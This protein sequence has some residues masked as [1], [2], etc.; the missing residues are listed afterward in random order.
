MA[1]QKSSQINGKEGK[2]EMVSLSRFFKIMDRMRRAWQNISPGPQLNKSQFVTLMTIQALGNVGES[3]CPPMERGEG[4]AGNGRPGTQ[5][6]AQAILAGLPAGA[7]AGIKGNSLQ[8]VRLGRIAKVLGQS[9]PAISQRISD[10]EAQGYVERVDDPR[11]RRVSSVRLTGAGHKRLEEAY[12]SL[13]RKLNEAIDAMGRE[14][15]AQMMNQLEQVAEYLENW[16]TVCGKQR[17]EG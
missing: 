7:P 16:E 8:P 5:M 13:K 14:Q 10:L 6:H 12:E 11:D 1:E 15:A 9:L 3:P 17:N 4:R 2:E